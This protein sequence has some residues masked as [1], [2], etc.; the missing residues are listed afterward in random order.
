MKT[1]LAICFSFECTWSC[2]AHRAAGVSDKSQLCH[3]DA[4]ATCSMLTMMG[5]LAKQHC[6]YSSQTQPLDLS[7]HALGRVVLRMVVK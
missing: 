1:A 7:A 6:M 2:K 3:G 5:P 4:A